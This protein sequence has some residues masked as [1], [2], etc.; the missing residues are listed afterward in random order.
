MTTAI[1]P[2]TWQTTRILAAPSESFHIC[3]TILWI[4]VLRHLRNWSDSAARHLFTEDGP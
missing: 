4:D 1:K 3:A 2:L